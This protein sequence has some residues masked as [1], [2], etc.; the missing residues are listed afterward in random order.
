[1]KHLK[2]LILLSLI[3]YSVVSKANDGV[4]YGSGNHLIPIVETRIS[5]KKEILSIKKVGDYFHVDVYYEMFNPDNAKSL[6]VGFEAPSPA[7][8]VSDVLPKNGK[9]PFMSD[10]TVNLNDIPLNY[11]VAF[12]SD[13]AYYSNG[14][15]KNETEFDSENYEKYYDYLYVYHFKAK[16]N[17]GLNKI[18]HTYKIK[19]SNS[20]EDEFSF[21]Y[22]LSAAMRWGNKQIDDF[23][24]TI[25]VGEFQ[26]VFID[27]TFYRSVNEWQIMG[28]G[29]MMNND[30]FFYQ[31]KF[32]EFDIQNGYLLFQKM[33]FKVEGELNI[34]AIWP[35]LFNENMSQDTFNY[36]RHKLV[37]QLTNPFMFGAD[38]LS[39]K[40]LRNLP[41]A[42]RGY[43][44]K[45]KDIQDY[46][47]K[48]PW[49]RRDP[50]YEATL[51]ELTDEEKNW[52][53]LIK[54]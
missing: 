22:I 16:F 41:Y 24:L 21:S 17:K 18:K 3:S 39:L 37:F 53:K 31:T 10:F 52:L 38:E 7:G 20:V 33:N 11:K 45:S 43:V 19:A 30:S 34:Q 26:T 42:R 44:F 36:K 54:I 50:N 2:L 12:V 40:I 15:Y 23:T 13:S 25:D 8:D 28:K 49:Y 5:I 9:H 46:F 4:F 1:M 48:M 51:S 47:D 6:E 29:K 35:Y 32:G 14:I 27:R